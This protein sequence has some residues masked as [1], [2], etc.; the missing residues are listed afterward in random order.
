MKSGPQPMS[1]HQASQITV[2]FATEDHVYF[3]RRLRVQNDQ[4]E[5]REV[6]D[7]GILKT[8]GPIIILGEPGMGKSAMV[9]ELGRILEVEPVTATRFMNSRNP[10]R[11]VIA[12]KPL[13]IDGLDEAMARREGDAVDL[14]LA[15]LEEAGKPDFILSCRAREWQARSGNNL[16]QLYGADPTIFA[17]EPLNRLEAAAFLQQGH[18]EVDGAHVLDHLDTHGIADLYRNPLTLDLMGQVAEVDAQLP[19]TRA[20]LFDRVCHLIWP[21][22]DVD[23]QD[24]DLGT[25][26]EDQALSAAGA[27]MAGLMFAGADAASLAGPA[28]LQDG[29]VRLADFDAL[30]GAEAARVVFSSKLFRS[31][32]IGRAAPIHRVIAEFL[33]ARWL[34]RSIRTKRAQRRLLGQLQGG[35]GVPA[36]LRGL[37]AWL[38]FHSAAMAKDVIAADPFG[39]LRYGEAAKLTVAQAEYMLEA[40][41]RLAEVDPFFRAQ[42]W[43]R[44]TI[45]GLMISSLQEKIG[46]TISSE[47]SNEHLRSL[48]L[49]G[50]LD[51]P[52]SKNLAS[53]LEAVMLAT[54]RFYHERKC[55]CDA[56]MPYRDRFWWQNAVAELC[57]QGSESSSRLALRIIEA[58]DCDISDELLVAALLGDMDIAPAP[59]TSSRKRRSHTFRHYGQIINSLSKSRLIGITNLVLG[60]SSTAKDLDHIALSD[61]VNLVSALTV[62]AIDEG[63]VTSS[64]AALLWKWLEVHKHDDHYISEEKKALLILLREKEDLRRAIQHYALFVARPR[65]TILAT[66]LDMDDRLVGLSRSPGD[67][68]YFLEQMGTTNNTDPS[69][70]EEWCDLMRLGIG[71][72]GFDPALRSASRKFQR[73]EPQLEVFAIGLENPE[74]P[75]WKLKQER[76]SAEREQKK[77]TDH[78]N[79]RRRYQEDRQALRAGDFNAILNPARAYM[80]LFNDLDREQ[81]RLNRIVEWLGSD[82][83]NDARIG[84]EAVLHRT[85]IPSA[86]QVASS[87]A[88][89]RTWNYCLAIL[90][91]MLERLGAKQGFEDLSKEV[92]SIGLLIAYERTWS[93]SNDD[94]PA[95]AAALGES[96]FLTEQDREK[97]AR[98]WIEPSL[99]VKATHIAGLYR[100]ANE[101][102]W[103]STGAALAADWIVSFPDLPENIELDLVDCLTHSFAFSALS[104][105]ATRMAERGYR[106]EEHRLAW[107]AIEVLVRFEAT[108]LNLSSIGTQH[109]QFIWYLRNR[110]QIQRRGSMVPVG[111]SQAKWI[112]AEFRSHWPYA[113]MEGTSSGD[114]NPFDATDFIRAMI[115][116]IADD[117]SSEASVAMHELISGP[118]DTYSDLIRHM[119]AEQRQKRVEEGFSPLSP[120]ELGALLTEGPP[121]NVEDLKSL[122]V[123]ELASAQKILIGDDLDHVNFFWSD[124]SVPYDEN[125]CRDR[126]AAMIGPELA[127]YDVQRITEADMPQSKRADLAF[128]RG[129]LQ[130]PMEIK[131]QWHPEMWD[132]ATNQLDLRYLIDWRS[133]QRG[134]YCV[135]WF[136]E[137]P[138]ASGRRL[139]APPKGQSNPRSSEELRKML[140]ERIPEARRSLIDVVVLD[141]S[142]GGKR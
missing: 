92:R 60:H 141:F 68:T 23:R 127:R 2:Q 44:H 113:I 43:D 16:R 27:I 66:E 75:A 69:K 93:D 139:Q 98:L 35:G 5:E 10:G 24:M 52:L 132:A 14:V 42:A 94:L 126:L 62:R 109:P 77:Q 28:Q 63:A 73:D 65:P 99:E 116:R 9:R 34:A 50:L 105:I 67:V 135:L 78:E 56:L 136:G 48:L 114:T 107:L 64:D 61:F 18:P 106:T 142:A 39:V 55:A 53:T 84:F 13:L 124:A 108:R 22:H 51:S 79:D 25:I 123:E 15:Q 36:S 104:T 38:A 91:G 121:S 47:R 4:G 100:L 21:E 46:S 130:L 76:E 122:V 12:G 120:S 72:D 115:G 97:F 118:P 80:G 129:Q 20:G 82:L 89:G 133:E 110:F 134:I 140:I 30:P 6:D 19:A 95:L 112:V 101:A 11:F 3:P 103:Q 29:D 90:A 71:Q 49:E 74:K 125:R 96:L 59:S 138:S 70:R 86:Q 31:I 131:G 40:L 7:I 85:D 137:L 54:Q 81:S 83:A 119:A 33:G 57:A 102:E 17:L 32:G 41:Q 88:R 128:S 8:S 111:I 87:F 45:S 58:I 117:S 1:L 26:N 37:H